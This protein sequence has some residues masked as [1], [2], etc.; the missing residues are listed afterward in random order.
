[1]RD[2]YVRK[3]MRICIWWKV[4][5][6]RKLKGLRSSEG[7]P[8][9][10]EVN[11]PNKVAD[12]VSAEGPRKHKDPKSY[13]CR[14]PGSVDRQTHTNRGRRGGDGGGAFRAVQR[15]EVKRWFLLLTIRKEEV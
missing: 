13:H 15:V 3:H 6:G 10:Y 8:G 4:G 12:Y 7:P 11:R 9:Q 14:S 1:M 2:T 5:G